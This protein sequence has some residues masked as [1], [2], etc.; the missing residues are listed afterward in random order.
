MSAPPHQSLDHVVSSKM[1]E[2]GVISV[3]VG[4]VIC[5]QMAA[6]MRALLKST[7]PE[8]FKQYEAIKYPNG[9]GN[10]TSLENKRAA[11]R[12]LFSAARDLLAPHYVPYA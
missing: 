9:R 7:D 12:F 1:S 6:Q 3:T 8:A 10:D 4:S 5:S 2:D 11:T